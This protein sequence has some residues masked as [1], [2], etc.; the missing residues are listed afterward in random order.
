M[1]LFTSAELDA[2]ATLVYAQMPPT[3]QHNWPLL[4]EASGANVWVKHENHTPIGA[5]KIRGGITLINWLKRTQ[6][7]CR[8]IITA[9]RGNH[10][11]SLARAARAAGLVAK[12]LVPRGNSTEK[13]AA[14]RA[15]GA[16]LVEFGDDFDESRVE[17]FRLA[18]VENLYPVPPYHGALT[19]GVATYALELF[20]AVPDLDTVYV[21]IGG[22]TG[23]C[24][25]IAVRDLLGLK[26]KV[27][28]VVSSE[29]ECARL[30]TEAGHLV[31]TETART[32][33]DGMAVRVPVADSLAIY[34]HGAERFVTVTDDEIAQA[35]RLYY[36]A[37]HNIAEGAGA[38]ALA[39][40][41]QEKN[42]M[43]GKK[44]ALILSGGNVDADWFAEVLQGGTPAPR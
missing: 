14:M 26:T 35:M 3:P 12:V 38:A 31:E 39:G 34:A 25:V 8:G 30:S 18:E 44:V 40:L 5:F 15:L 27:V 42:R 6:P 13:N 41:M 16:D 19:V 21:P 37:T 23:I 33:A 22:G 28:A 2:A 10:G 43:Q 32:I 29:A 1:S 7:D 4:S 17:A 36:R 11:Q 9:T 20:T 24:G